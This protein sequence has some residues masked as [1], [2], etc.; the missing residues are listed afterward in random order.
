MIPECHFHNYLYLNKEY[1]S[2][3][4]AELF[5]LNFLF[6]IMV[7]ISSIRFSYRFTPYPTE[8]LWMYSFPQLQN[9]IVQKSS[10]KVGMNK[11][12]R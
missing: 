7:S 9:L 10:C 6:L 1:Y 4:T 5:I 8:P 12:K 2:F 3:I 11:Y